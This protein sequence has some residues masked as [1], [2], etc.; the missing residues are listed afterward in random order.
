MG[1]N[2][3]EMLSSEV[4]S[5]AQTDQGSV[6]LL[7]PKDMDVMMPVF[8]SKFEV[9]SI[10]IGKEGVTL[11]RPLTHDLF[12]NMLS[13]LNLT[14][15]RVEIYEV[16]DNTLYARLVIVGG[17]FT[18]E[19]PLVL[20]A[21][22][23]DAIALAVRRRYPVLISAALIKRAG[24]PLDFFDDSTDEAGDENA[25]LFEAEEMEEDKRQ[26]LRDQLDAAIAVEKYERAAEIRD[27][28][29]LMEKEKNSD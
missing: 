28:L 23:S 22:P 25:D 10:L 14:L 6:V 13:R 3:Q 9:Q 19:K 29:K 1:E 7:R 12:L 24:L 4:W 16:R 15:H 21:R 18:R 11:P 20:D 26:V 8:T 17:E 2:M 27:L 5:I